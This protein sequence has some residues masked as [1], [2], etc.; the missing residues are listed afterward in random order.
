MFS[1]TFQELIDLQDSIIDGA[2]D[3][4][5]IP[6]IK[7]LEEL[8]DSREYSLELEGKISELLEDLRLANLENDY[9]RERLGEI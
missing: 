4:D 6:I 7:I 9:L 3:R 5:D 1:Y 2:I 8:V